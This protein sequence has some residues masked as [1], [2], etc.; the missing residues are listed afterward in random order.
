MIARSGT[1]HASIRAEEVIVRK[2]CTCLSVGVAILAAFATRGTAQQVTSL[3]VGSPG[4]VGVPV[5]IT[6][7]GDRSC[8]FKLDFGDGQTSDF[9][10][11]LPQRL[12]HSYGRVGTYKV[13]AT[14]AAPC[15]GSMTLPLEVTDQKSPQRL[16]GVKV[17]TNIEH[18]TTNAFTT[19]VVLGSGSCGYTIDFGDGTQARRTESLPDL[20]T[21]TYTVPKSYTILA[22]AQAPCE[23]LAKGGVAM[24]VK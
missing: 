23:G 22:T 2:L 20:V 14:A 8:A 6:V 24:M 9:A 19:I 21:H 15:M 11:P 16:T 13:V 7:E 17:S 10:A 1:A 12:T 4:T 18:G 3:A 5:A